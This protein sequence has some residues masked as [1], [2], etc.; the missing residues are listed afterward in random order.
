ML[1]SVKY[2]SRIIGYEAN[3]LLGEGNDGSSCSVS[4]TSVSL[5][6]VLPSSMTRFRAFV[7]FAKR[8]SAQ[9]T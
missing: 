2:G 3:T 1:R 5:L 8:L 9:G 4:G 7:E 6:F